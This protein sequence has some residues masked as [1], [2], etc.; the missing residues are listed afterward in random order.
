MKLTIREIA[1]MA[2]VSPATVSKIMNNYGGIS[3][4]TKEKVMNIID[5]TGYQPTFSAKSLA[6]K[7]SNLIGLIYA[8]KINVELN[9][10][11]FNDVVN[12]FKKTVG[13]MGYD[14]LIFSNEKFNKERDVDYLPRARH[15]QVDGCLI[16]AGEEIESAIYDLDQSEI[17]CVGVDIE[18]KGPK[19]SYV[20]TD[21]RKVSSKV[22]E[23]LYLHSIRDIAYI[24]GVKDSPISMVRT[25][26]FIKTMNQFGFPIREEWMQYGNFH[27]QSGYDAMNRILSKKPYPKAVFAASDM[28]ALGAMAAIREHGLKIPEDIALI[29]CDDIEACRYSAPRLTTVK[30][31]KEKL[32]RLAANMLM[33]IINGQTEPKTVLV[34]PELIVRESCGVLKNGF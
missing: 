10:P 11:F 27:E 9:H 16:I 24:G 14:I 32:G 33:D 18:L 22:I 30:Q 5:S 13:M 2:G 15:F 28:M 26:G 4:E 23:H 34:D 6:T 20:M 17:P 25:E 12:A 7:K 1:K 31:D 19:S 21:N 8:G 3:N 29:G